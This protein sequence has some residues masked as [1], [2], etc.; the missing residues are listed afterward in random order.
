MVLAQP[1]HE[2]VRI[3]ARGKLTNDYF[4]YLWWEMALPTG[5]AF[6]AV[7]LKAM[8]ECELAAIERVLQRVFAQ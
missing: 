7:T 2:R 1:L 8:S 6:D 4:G 5:K 3:E